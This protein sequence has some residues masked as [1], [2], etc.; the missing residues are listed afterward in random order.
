MPRG[1]WG[2]CGV[3][4]FTRP[5]SA[6]PSFYPGS[7]RSLARALVVISIVRGQLVSLRVLR[8]SLGSLARALLAVAGSY[9]SDEGASGRWMHPGSLD[10][11]WVHS[12]E[13]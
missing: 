12:H 3:V 10:G 1:T 5:R 13:S 7:L 4:R 11:R 6:G 9:G 2:S 8:E